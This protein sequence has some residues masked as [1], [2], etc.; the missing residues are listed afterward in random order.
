MANTITLTPFVAYYGD[1]AADLRIVGTKVDSPMKVPHYLGPSSNE[2]WPSLGNL[3]PN[4]KVY[5]ESIGQSGGGGHGFN[6][7]AGVAVL[8]S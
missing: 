3:Y 1:P 6:V 4:A 7:Y 5:I 2:V 8:E